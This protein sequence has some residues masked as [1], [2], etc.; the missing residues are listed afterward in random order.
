[1]CTEAGI[2]K[3]SMTSILLGLYRF[4]VLGIEAGKMRLQHSP[5]N[6]RT[7]TPHHEM[8][9]SFIFR[10]HWCV[11]SSR[12]WRIR[13]KETDTFITCRVF[14]LPSSSGDGILIQN[15]LHQY[16]ITNDCFQA[17]F[18]TLTFQF[19]SKIVSTGLCGEPA[20][21]I[22]SNSIAEENK[23]E[24][25]FSLKHRRSIRRIFHQDNFRRQIY[26]RKMSLQ[27]KKPSNKVKE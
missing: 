15:I 2:F 20:S 1:M 26:I 21:H 13:W 23:A 3:N 4:S 24:K 27:S 5:L 12:T 9:S 7:F 22:L 16:I 25:R 6:F 19:Q 18:D 14:P 17:L 11:F 8:H 10:S